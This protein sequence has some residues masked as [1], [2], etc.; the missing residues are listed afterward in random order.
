MFFHAQICDDIV[1]D[2]D[3][4]LDPDEDGELEYWKCQGGTGEGQTE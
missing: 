3:R 1:L 4:L 2:A